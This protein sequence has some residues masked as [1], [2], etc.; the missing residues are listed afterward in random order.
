MKIADD[1][2]KFSIT[3]DEYESRLI[4][5]AA[6]IVFAMHDEMPPKSK[7]EDYRRL[8]RW[9]VVAFCR[10]VI[11]HGKIRFP[12]AVD[13]RAENPIEQRD[14][15]ARKIPAPGSGLNQCNPWN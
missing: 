12:V 5:E 13:V 2:L 4:R 1:R 10:A 15:I 11:Q 8:V 9:A 14:R 6:R 3:F 7:R